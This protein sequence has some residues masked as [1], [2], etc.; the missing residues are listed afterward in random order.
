MNFFKSYILRIA[1][2]FA[3]VATISCEDDADKLTGKFDEGNTTD[4]SSRITGFDVTKTGGGAR[5]TVNGTDLGGVDRA[6]IAGII[7]L[8]LEVSNEAV[9][10]TIPATVPLGEQEVLLIFSGPGRAI[11]TI[12]VV[13]LPVISHISTQSGGEGDV[14][15][16]YG[17]NFQFVTEAKIGETAATVSNVTNESLTVTVP[18][19][20]ETG[21]ITVISEAGS[22]VSSETFYSCATDPTNLFC[23]TAVNANGDF[24]LG[25][26]GVVA[27][28]Q[29]GATGGNW[30]L[31]GSGVR[32]TYEVVTENGADLGSRTVKATITNLGTNNYEIQVVNDGYPVAANRRWMFMGKVHSDIDGRQ[33]RVTGG[34]SVPGYQDMIGGTDI[35][36]ES[37]WNQFAVEIQHD[38]TRSQEE[39]QIRA[40]CNF[41][42]P[43]NAGAVM[44]FDDFRIVDMGEWL[45]CAVDPDSFFALYGVTACP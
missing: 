26:L 34:V 29:P 8:D 35:V 39:V 6:L 36:L 7:T 1:V 4:L 14:V 11:A 33:I 20:S 9:S 12:E 37:G 19:N 32:A 17:N 43:A 2:V 23:Q 18:A 28:G 24:E 38:K 13:P 3:L 5:L 15:E 41:S 30:F 45:D 10:F 31:A 21:V 22:D 44:M 25:T 16:V 40:Q 27:T 42:Y